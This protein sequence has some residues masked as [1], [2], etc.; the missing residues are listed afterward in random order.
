M[1]VLF[2]NIK[3]A[4][5]FSKAAEKYDGSIIVKDGSVSVD[6]ESLIGLMTL[7]IN[8]ILDVEISD[9]NSASAVQFSQEVAKLGIER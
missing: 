2:K 1:K 9:P 4:E 7:G 8:K 5:R 6:G 3:Q